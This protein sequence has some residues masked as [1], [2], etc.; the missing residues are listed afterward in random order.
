MVHSVMIAC[1]QS[2]KLMDSI[3]KRHGNH[4]RQEEYHIEGGEARICLILNTIA[5]VEE[6]LHSISFERYEE[7][8]AFANSVLETENREEGS[9]TEQP[10]VERSSNREDSARRIENDDA[11]RGTTHVAPGT[12]GPGYNLVELWLVAKLRD[13]S[14]PN[15]MFSDDVVSSIETM[16]PR[17]GIDISSAKT[18]L[19][20][21]PG[22]HYGNPTIRKVRGRGFYFRRSLTVRHCVDA[23]LM[24]EPVCGVADSL[25]NDAEE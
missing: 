7:L 17:C 6:S 14:L 2:E 5:R 25:D 9:M 10:T 19:T 24:T 15:E 1:K 21:I 13:G 23:G 16:F 12:N 4:V 18:V 22:I 20:A 8:L 3:M 11:M